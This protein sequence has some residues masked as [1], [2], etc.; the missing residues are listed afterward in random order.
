MILIQNSLSLIRLVFRRS[1]NR[2]FH[3]TPF[4]LIS[5]LVLII[6]VTL[7]H[8]STIHKRKDHIYFGENNI[9]SF[10]SNS[11]SKYVNNNYSN[12]QSKFYNN[13][14]TRPLLHKKH[15][16]KACLSIVL[17]FKA[18]SIARDTFL[19]LLDHLN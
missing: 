7:L 15:L 19:V 2:F 4:L 17:L 5:F 3:L 18:Q 10:S 8:L 6:F 16:G 13:V 11:F 12:I 14:F 1:V 9:I